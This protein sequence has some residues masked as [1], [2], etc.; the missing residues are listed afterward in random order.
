MKK[1]LFSLLLGYAFFALFP[2]ELYSNEKGS[3]TLVLTLDKA[4]ELAVDSSLNTFIAENLYLASYWEYNT[5]RA[6]RLPFLEMHTNPANFRRAMTQEYNYQEGR[7][8]YVEQQ[9]LYSNLN[10]SINQNITF[11]GGQIFVDSDLGR[12]ENFGDISSLQY[13]SV[14]VRVGIRQP[15]FGYNRFKWEK[16]IEPVKYERARREVVETMEEIAIETVR[17]FFDLAAA[18]VNLQIAETQK[19]NADTLLKIGQKRFEI[20]SISRNDLYMLQLEQINAGN[21]L[22]KAKSQLKRAQM[23]LSSFLRLDADSHIEIILPED[24]PILQI[25]G[26]QSLEMAMSNNPKMLEL[27]QQLLE[28][29]S[30]VERTRRESRLNANLN[31]SFGLNQVADRFNDVYQDPMDQQIVQLGISIPLLDWGTAKGK[32]N[33]AKHNHRVITAY[34]DQAEIDFVQNIILTTEEFNRQQ[35]VVKGSATADSIAHEAY[36]HTIDRFIAGQVDILR[37]SSSQQA[38]ISARMSYINALRDYWYYFYNI[39]RFTLYDF[40]NKKSLVYDFDESFGVNLQ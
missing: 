23:Y 37:L 19:A 21:N 31:M 38:S 14:P 15:L 29:E 13:T 36:E 34:A 7:Y 9:T 16:K 6:Q 22:E 30:D 20:A 3:N 11:T 39:R 12:L 4:I 10:L 18:Q 8:E 26:S 27:K 17:L 40:L 5:Y 1:G 2:C 25:D 35:T 32:Y 28:S 24:I 33:L